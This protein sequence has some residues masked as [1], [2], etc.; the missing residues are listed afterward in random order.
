MI[1]SKINLI[2]GD[3]SNLKK[4]NGI[5]VD[6]IVNAAKP[7][8]M[9]GNGVDGAIHK[10]VDALLKDEKF[11]EKIKNKFDDGNYPDARTRCN[12]GDAVV[13][14]GY[15]LCKHIIHAV[16]PK[17]DEGSKTSFD[18]LKLTYTRILDLMV[19]LGHSTIAIPVISSGSYG[20]EFNIAARIQI[21]SVYNYLLKLKNKD[22]F[23]Y[24][25][26]KKI[27]FVIF[28]ESDTNQYIEV[29]GKYHKYMKDDKQL[30]LL[31]SNE[32]FKAYKTE[33]EINDYKK[34]NYF[35]LTKWFRKFLVFSDK[36][37]F[38]TYNLKRLF[39]D[40]NW[41]LR[42]AFIEIQ[43]IIKTLLSIFFLFYDFNNNI[44]QIVALVVS[45]TMMLETIIYLSKIVF[46]A[47]IQNASANIYRSILFIFLNCME[48]VFAFAFWYK[49]SGALNSGSIVA[50]S[51]DYLH[52]SF[53]N[54]SRIPK[55]E[56][57]EYLVCLQTSVQF[58]IVVIIVA[59]FMGNFNK[60]KFNS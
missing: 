52:F 10:E 17:W 57:G 54:S 7:T 44:F 12:H 58:Y 53:V 59:Y 20:F 42:R 27:Y 51:I 47:D 41:H 3:I 32:S 14:E 16:G 28:Q 18:K 5:C 39:A 21:V 36:L 19:D 9:G 13:T 30:L 43:V 25:R 4:N 34:R 31:N 48:I 1:K 26:I 37:F 50:K 46:L 24:D 38:V 45:I 60:L 11:T 23:A 35:G 2:T 29:L 33:I 22:K 8:L 56:F 40:K 55:S 6:V 49:S 15:G